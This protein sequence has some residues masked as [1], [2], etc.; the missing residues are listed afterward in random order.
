MDF[1]ADR[2]AGML[3]IVREEIICR[4]VQS[5]G[6]HDQELKA[7]ISASGFYIAD[8]L[9]IYSNGLTKILLGHLLI[10][11]VSFDAL[12]YTVVVEGHRYTLACGHLH[13]TVP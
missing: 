10:H 4:N 13:I 7:R 8:M 11:S 5:V 12:A 2:R 9:I 1:R 6:D 3:E